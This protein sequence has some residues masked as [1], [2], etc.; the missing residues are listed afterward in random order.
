MIAQFQKSLAWRM[1]LYFGILVTVSLVLSA[2]L[3]FMYER[4]VLQESVFDRLS[5]LR[6]TQKER[7]QEYLKERMDFVR[8]IARSR[9]VAELIA[10]AAELQTSGGIDVR[11]FVF[12]SLWT[13]GPKS[14]RAFEF[15]RGLRGCGR[16]RPVFRG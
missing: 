13:F 6:E 3:S 4:R 11:R 7:I 16:S 9:E 14:A 12:P 15:R 1:A 10:F 8:L 5:G 2:V